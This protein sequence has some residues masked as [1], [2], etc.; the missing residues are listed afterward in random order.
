[1]G[2]C[3]RKGI[4]QHCSQKHAHLYV[5]EFDFRYN[6]YEANDIDDSVRA[7]EALNGLT[8]VKQKPEK[9]NEQ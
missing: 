8:V 4:Y 5:A 6:I 3:I 1:M 7:I 9:S 2:D